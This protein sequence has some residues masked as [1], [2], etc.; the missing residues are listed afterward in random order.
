[1]QSG[2]F[3]VRNIFRSL[4]H[5]LIVAETCLPF[6]VHRKKIDKNIPSVPFFCECETFQNYFSSYHKI[7][8]LAIVLSLAKLFQF[9]RSAF[10]VK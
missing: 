5:Q 4:A 2:L 1:M 10:N 3:Y 8:R 9:S 7:T 6:S